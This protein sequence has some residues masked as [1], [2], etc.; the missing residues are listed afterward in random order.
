MKE[1]LRASLI[2]S[3]NT[4]KPLIGVATGS[5]FSAKQAVAGGADFLLVL[6]AGLF[7]N[8]GVSTL[9]S[10]LPFANSNEMVLKTGYREILPHAGETPVI[11]GVCATD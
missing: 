7:R 11:Y 1:K 4:K 3:L 9:G 8:A 5:G 10:L 2:D 6:N